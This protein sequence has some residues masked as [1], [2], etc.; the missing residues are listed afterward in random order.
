VIGGG[1]FAED[2]IIPDCF[3]AA[4]RGEAITLRNPGSVRPYQHVLDT[5]LAYLLIARRQYEDAAIAGSYNVGP[6]AEGCVTS[7]K[8][9]ELFCKEWGEGARWEHRHVEN[10]HESGLLTLNCDRIKRVLG[11]SPRWDIERSVSA[12]AEWY[13]ELRKGDA[14]AV[15]EGQIGEFINS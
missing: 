6:K 10:P 15:M 9:A 12:A 8:L 14:N 3:R 4:D 2:R 1:D 11:W 5:L 7:G 13:R